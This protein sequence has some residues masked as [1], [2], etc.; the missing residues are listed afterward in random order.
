VSSWRAIGLVARREFTERGR[1]RSFHISTGISILILLAVILIPKAFDLGGSDASRVGLLGP[2][3]AALAPYLAAQQVD[4][5]AVEPSPVSGL[6]SAEQALRDGDLDAVVVD[7]RR[8]VS[9]E[10]VPDDLEAAIQ[11]ASAEAR[12]RAALEAAGLGAAQAE[13]ILAPPPL[14]ATTLAPQDEDEGDGGIALVAVIVLYGQL[15]GYVFWVASGVVE[16]KASRIV[17]ILL[18][19]ITA[20]QLLAGK[21]IGIGLLGFLQLI[22]IAAVALAAAIAADV[23][24]DP[25]HAIGAV[26]VALAWFVLGFAF[27]ACLFA[28]AGATISRVEELQNATTPLT[29]VILGSFALSFVAIN[30]PDGM[31]A[32]V[33][34]IVPPISA[35]VMPPRI[36]AGDVAA[37]EIGLAVAL[38]IAATC[39]LVPLAAR[40]YSNAVLQTGGRIRLRD[41]WRSAAA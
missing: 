13:A 15:F 32:Q 10:E 28:V 1:E 20:R 41:A 38:M 35:M 27:Y 12:S 31:L 8:I 9:D 22:G 33:A 11:L 17:E 36:V 23:I 6:A 19:T 7:G 39:A 4:D 3:S 34:S 5:E 14:P 29:V 24:D 2:Q 37:W 30:N 26:L 18:S 21:V 40:V 25:G 16:E